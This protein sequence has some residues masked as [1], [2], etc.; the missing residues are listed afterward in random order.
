MECLIKGMVVGVLLHLEWDSSGAIGEMNS[1][2]LLKA[3]VV[4]GGN[5]MMADYSMLAGQYAEA[6]D[7]VQNSCWAENVHI[8]LQ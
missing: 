8:S 1:D 4:P 2:V 6:Q 7:R 5:Q 3:Y